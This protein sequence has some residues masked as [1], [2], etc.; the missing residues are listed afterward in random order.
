MP[1]TKNRS[2][3]ANNRASQEAFEE[4]LKWK[5][6]KPE[7]AI[8]WFTKA[9]NMGHAKAAHELEKLRIRLSMEGSIDPDSHNR[10]L[11][12][13]NKKVSKP[14]IKPSISLW[15]QNRTIVETLYSTNTQPTRNNPRK[16]Q[17]KENR[18]SQDKLPTFDIKSLKEQAKNGDSDAQ[19]KCGKWYL[20]LATKCLN[21][22]AEQGHTAARQLLADISAP[23]AP[24]VPQPPPPPPAPEPEP[25]IENTIDRELLYTATELLYYEYSEPVENTIDGEQLYTVTELLYYEYSEAAENTIDGEQLYTVTELLHY[26]YS[27][28]IT[29]VEKY[30][31][32]ALISKWK[33]IIYYLCRLFSPTTVENSP[34]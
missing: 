29:A 18:K 8:V 1:V 31:L 17:Q 16:T 13:T 2:R 5:F 34:K 32:T 3:E 15:E 9:A 24:E 30:F 12:E 23:K 25:E 20:K 4:G 33:K 26:E 21:K 19:Y 7:K 22:A 11:E 28:P 10:N 6:S 14:T 27:E